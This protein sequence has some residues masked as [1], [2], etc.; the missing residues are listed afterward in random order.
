M[1]VLHGKHCG[2]PGVLVRDW[3]EKVTL[4]AHPW[5]SQDRAAAELQM[6]STSHA[7]NAEG[8]FHWV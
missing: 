5:V 7:G 2:Y 6:G 3:W 8:S 1:E 4:F